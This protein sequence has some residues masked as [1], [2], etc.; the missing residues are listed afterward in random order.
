MISNK[1]MAQIVGHYE[2]IIGRL[3]SQNAQLL[4]RLMARNLEEFK[5]AEMTETS[6]K[7]LTYSPV[8][9]PGTIDFD[10]PERG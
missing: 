7:P 3:E 1:T 9:V 5:L 6:E 8:Q 2:M 10:L 4:D